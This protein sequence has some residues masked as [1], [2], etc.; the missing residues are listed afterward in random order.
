MDPIKTMESMALE[1]ISNNN[2]TVVLSY[3][4]YF[5][6]ACNHMM[7]CESIL[8]NDITQVNNMYATTAKVLKQQFA[9]SQED[10]EAVKI[11]KR[12]WKENIKQWFVKIWAFIVS[13][14]EKIALAVVSFVKSMIV[15]ITKK[16]MASKDMVENVKAKKIC[17]TKIC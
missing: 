13:I 12:D 10:I 5:R 6:E 2:D 8:Q 7:A 3:E 17:H 1:N 11:V 4:S 14:F 15:Y 16:R 9:R